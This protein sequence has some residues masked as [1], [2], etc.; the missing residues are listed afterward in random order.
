MTKQVSLN[1]ADAGAAGTVKALN[2]G[3]AAYNLGICN[4]TYCHSDGV[5]VAAGVS[6]NWATGNISGNCNDCH[7]NSPTTGAHGVH[8]V[9]IHYEELYDKNNG[10]LLEAT[11]SVG[12]GAAHGDSVISSTI[13]CFTCHKDTVTDSANATNS[14]CGSCHADSGTVIN[15]NENARILTTSS[16]HIN[17]LK[18]VAFADLSTFKSPAQ[19]RDNLADADDGTNL[20]SAIWNRITGYKG[21]S[22]YDTAQAAF[23]TPSFTQGPDTCSTTVCHNG[24][25]ATWSDSGVDCLYCHTS[26]PK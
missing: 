6:P 8:E 4:A 7:G 9:G 17:G 2:N 26:L 10:G 21:G 5:D 22:D 24:N 12:S 1:P 16:T 11:G 14:T 3:S 23:A 20:L 13:S 19:L 15:G 18:D 25:T